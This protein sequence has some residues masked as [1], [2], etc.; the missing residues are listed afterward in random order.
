[1]NGVDMKIMST[2][3]VLILALAVAIGGCS[4]AKKQLG[5]QRNVPDEF[6][7]VK[8][9]PLSMPP[10]Y[11]L[12]PPQPGAPRPQEQAP[13]E[14]AKDVVFGAQEGGAVSKGE[15]ENALLQRAGAQH[16]DPGIRHKVDVETA[17]ISKENIPVARKL[18]GIGGDPNTA[19]TQ[20]VNAKAE[21]ERLQKNKEQGKPATAGETPTV[22]R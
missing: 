11:K 15:G 5:L 22:E 13:Y 12:A 21:T 16:A 6:A 17:E 9:A 14:Q 3:L 20:V 2:K 18:F 1:M 19:P 8:R 10:D 4:N 7:V